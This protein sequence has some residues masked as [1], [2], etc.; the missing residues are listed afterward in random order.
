M[1]ILIH[2]PYWETQGGGERYSLTVASCLQHDA[3][4][5]VTISSPKRLSEIASHLGLSVDRVNTFARPLTR[6]ELLKFS[7]IFW[8]SDGSIPFLPV[9]RRVIHFQTPFHSISG[10]STRN[11]IK[12]FGTTIVCNSV[13]TKQFIDTE[14]SVDSKVIYP[15]VETEKFHS[16]KKENLILSVGRFSMSSAHKRPDVLI[17]VFRLLVDGGVRGW[18][19]VIAGGVEDE[20][21]L[22]LIK[23]LR[24]SVKGYPIVIKTDLSHEKIISLFEKTSI[25]WHAAGFG[26][27]LV[28]Y[29]ERA[30]HFGISTVE[31]MAAGAV[32]CSYAAGGQTEIISDGVDGILWQTVPE[33]IRKTRYLIDSTKQMTQMSKQAVLKAQTFNSSR[34]CREIHKLF[35]D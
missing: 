22:D 4:V 2:S 30:E 29:P 14:F 24:M 18:R 10:S 12:L 31:A 28:N 5:Y 25:Y 16:Q 19:L 7:G 33:L 13:F 9:L 11:R 21:S 17:R 34:F 1:K 32:P 8:V 3:P 26:A 15:P 6:A 23:K 27:D 20:R 35:F